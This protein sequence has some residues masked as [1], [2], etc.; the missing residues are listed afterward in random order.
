MSLFFRSLTIPDISSE[1][2]NFNTIGTNNKRAR[3]DFQIIS[4]ITTDD[5]GNKSTIK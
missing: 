1:R 3:S 4:K 2:F 5:N